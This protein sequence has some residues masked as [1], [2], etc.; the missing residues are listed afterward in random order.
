MPAVS[1]S[2]N[3]T[4]AMPTERSSTSRVVPA[5]GVTIAAS[6]ASSALKSEDFPALGGPAS[7]TRTPS[8]KRSASGRPATRRISATRSSVSS[9]KPGGRPATSSSSAKSMTAS[10]A[11]AN[12]RTRLRHSSMRSDRLPPAERRAPC[13]CNSVSAASRSARPSASARSIR[14]FAKARR[15]NSP[16]SE[17]RKPSMSARERE[18]AAITA[19]PP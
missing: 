1:T 10:T 17:A 4:P 13:R 6:S 5:S 7:I 2:T 9:V 16:G 14:P 19:L 11:A 3:G 15:V 18:I 8:R 12:P